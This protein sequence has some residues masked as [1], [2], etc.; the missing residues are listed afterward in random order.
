[1]DA[2]EK[3]RKK[4]EE[5]D[6][7][8]DMEDEEPEAKSVRKGHSVG[9]FEEIMLWDHDAPPAATDQPF[10]WMKWPTVA[11]AVHGKVTVQ[12]MQAKKGV[13]AE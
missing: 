1:V 4:N 9:I 2:G 8:N 5:E 6:S 11:A 3:R 12:E 13:K 7:F 10:E